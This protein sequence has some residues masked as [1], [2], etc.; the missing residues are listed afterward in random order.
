MPDDDRLH[1]L[2]ASAG[3]FP[4]YNVADY[5]DRMPD[6]MLEKGGLFL[7][8]WQREALWISFHTTGLYQPYAIRIYVGHIN[9]V[10]GKNMM[11]KEP[12]ADG[13]PDP[14]QDHIIVPGQKWIDGVCVAPGVVRQF[15]AMPC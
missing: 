8:M 12:P 5:P 14:Q 2:P 4:L 13:R 10:T 11:D 9:A 1:S 6:S 3:Y 15:V 7:P